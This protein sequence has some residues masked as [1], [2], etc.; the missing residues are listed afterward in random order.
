MVFSLRKP[1]RD[2]Y[3]LSFRE[4]VMKLE[5]EID[6]IAMEQIMNRRAAFVNT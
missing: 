1:I 4:K 3:I 6:E 5:Q 2:A